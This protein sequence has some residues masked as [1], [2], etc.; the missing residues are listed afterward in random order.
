MATHPGEAFKLADAG[1]VLPAPRIEPLVLQPDFEAGDKSQYHVAELSAY[2]DRHFIESVYKAILARAPSPAERA[3]E[4]DELRSGRASKVEI[5][6]RL[7]SSSEARA[8]SGRGVRVEGL[9][10]P[11][12]RR[13][14]RM[15]V[16]GYV[17]R[18]VR[19]LLRLPL[20]MQHQRQFEIYA[21]AQQQLIADYLNRTLPRLARA[22]AWAAAATGAPPAMT[23]TQQ[24]EIAETLAMFSDALLELSSGHAELQAQVQTQVEQAQAALDELTAAVTAQQQ[25][26]DAF[27]REQQ[28]ATDAFHHQQQLAADALRREQQLTNDELR[29]EQ[30]LAHDALRREQQLANDAQQEFLI[31]EQQVIVETQQVVLAELREDLRELSARQ[32]RARDEFEAEVRRLRSLG[33]AAR[34]N[35]SGQA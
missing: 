6:E 1:D 10:S 14:G 11:L 5:I 22:D 13:L 8:G 4:L 26:G 29:R 25:L 3:H 30:Q 7:L 15:P 27:R 16:V 9:P 28:L 34:E 35:F 32:Q 20:S 17:L 12:L 19:A 24:E 21:L 2:H 31:Q 23:L 18:F 33:E